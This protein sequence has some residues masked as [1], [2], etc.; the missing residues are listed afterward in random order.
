MNN[1]APLHIEKQHSTASAWLSID[2][3][4]LAL[5]YNIFRD[6]AED[7]CEVAGVIKAD[8]Y[9]LGVDQVLAALE[10]QDC[11]F[12]FVATLDEALHVRRLTQ[13]PVAV[14]GGLYRGAEEEYIHHN[15]TPVLNSLH[16]IDLWRMTATQHGIALPAIVHFDTGMSRLGLGRDETA[17]L[18]ERLERLEGLHI[19]YMMTHLACADEKDHPMTAQQYELFT[20]ACAPFPQ[21]K[22][23]LCNSSGAF[24]AQAYHFD[25]IRPGMALYG[26]NPTPEKQNP[27]RPVVSLQAR[28]LQVRTVKKDESVGYGATYRF[29]KETKVATVALGYGDGFL[30]ALSSRPD[31]LARLYYNGTP[32]PI[33]GRVSMDAVTIDVGHLDDVPEPGDA[34]EVMGPHQDADALAS[35]A[36][37][38]GYE[39]LTDLGKRYHRDYVSGSSA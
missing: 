14:L 38:I 6:M 25:L 20:Q 9:G 39:I 29:N 5:N 15:I 23:S 35:A 18:H 4:A 32:C 8:G 3:G 28:I 34:V 22:K 37:T 31:R 12:Y 7:G 26:L 10:S 1:P 2:L 21:V 13:K 17:E 36:G 19:A 11:P 16:D 27:M 33:I 30:R 24:R